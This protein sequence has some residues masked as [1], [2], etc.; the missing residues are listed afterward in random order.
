[1]GKVIVLVPF[2]NPSFWQI[3]QLLAILCNRL[4]P[5]WSRLHMVMQSPVFRQPGCK[6]VADLFNQ[7]PE[8]DKCQ[9]E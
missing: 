1:M 8:A 5:A 2:Y 4:T 9:I 7:T 6:V 3:N